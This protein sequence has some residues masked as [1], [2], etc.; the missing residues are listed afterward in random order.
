VADERPDRDQLIEETKQNPEGVVDVLLAIWDRSAALEKRVG[1]LERNSRNSS[2][3]PSSDKGNLS[4]PPKPKPKSQRKP[5]GKKPGGQPGHKGSTLELVENP[6]HT[7]DCKI[8][9][10]S[11]CSI[12]GEVLPEDNADH[13]HCEPEIR[14]V[15]ELPAIR[16]EVAEYRAERV[17]CPSCEGLNTAPFPEGVNARAQ[18]GPNLR[19]TAIY[20]GSYQLI[21]YERLSEVFNDLFQCSLSQGTLANFVKVGGR[22]AATAVNYIREQIKTSDTVHADET[23][24]RVH[25]VRNW[26]HVASTQAYTCYMIHAKRGFEALQDFGILEGYKG[27]LIHDFYASYYKYTECQHFQC[28]AHILRELTYLHEEMDQGWAVDMK[29]LLLEAKQLRDREERR[30]PGQRKV[31]G[32][33]TRHRIQDRYADIVLDGYS[34]NAEPEPQ[35]GKRGKPARGKVLNLLDRFDWRYEEIMGF[36]E[37]EGIP[38]DNNLAERDLRMMKTREK[39]SGTFRSDK[40]TIAF[41]DIRSVISTLKKQGASVMTGITEMLRNPNQLFQKAPDGPE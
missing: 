27:N 39:I 12:C 30:R 8:E 23:G 7:I 35:P 32:E 26:L 21:P 31:I 17:I 14:Q 36:F 9:E 20:L 10:G 28:D 6:D 3:P 37:Y 4:T 18:Y 40:H 13:S 16:L 11:R 1:E 22:Q 15:F 33:Q 38:F 5:S 2:K 29:D 41:C 24:C 34:K 19:A 25:G